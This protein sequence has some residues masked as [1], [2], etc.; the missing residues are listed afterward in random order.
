[1]YPKSNYLNYLTPRYWPLWFGLLLL[2]LSAFLPYRVMRMLSHGLAFLVYILLPSRKH[3]AEVNIR[4]CFP[5]LTDAEVQTMVK[6]SIYS[7]AMSFF[8]T[9][10]AWW[11]SGKRMEQMI[12]FEG[13]ENI[14]LE[15]KNNRGIILL[16]GHYTTLEISGRLL[17]YYMRD[18][19]PVYKAARN[20]LFNTIMVNSREKSISALLENS[21]MRK[22]ISTL[23][24]GK[25]IWYAPDQDFGPNNTVFAPFMGVETSTLVATSR[26]AKLSGAAV[27]PFYSTRLDNGEYTIRFGKALEDFP[28]EDDAKDASKINSAI[29]E[30]VRQYPEQYLWVHRRFKTRPVGEKG[31]YD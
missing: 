21:N 9:A 24:K 27:I 7:T 25:A 28:S 11:G 1:M 20:K 17:T 2:R 5:E 16:G 30:H 31:Y 8:E 29:E 12:H 4:L 6:G 14:E 10:L 18:F 26:L 23:K 19:H 22:I 3:I 13:V 15:K